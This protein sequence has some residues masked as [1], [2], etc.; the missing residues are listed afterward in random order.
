VANQLA[1]PRAWPNG[2]SEAHVSAFASN[3]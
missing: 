1:E 3:P 2:W